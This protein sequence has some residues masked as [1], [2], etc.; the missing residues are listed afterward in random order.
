MRSKV[1][2]L[3]LLLVLSQTGIGQQTV[4][5]DGER[6]MFGDRVEIL[7]DPTSSLT[8]EDVQKS[9][10]F[11]PSNST[12]PNM[13]ITSNAYWVRFNIVNASSSKD[14]SVQISYSLIDSISFYQLDGDRVIQ[15]NH[16][17]GMLPFDSRVIDEHQYYVYPIGTDSYDTVTCY[18]RVKSGTQLML[19]IYVGTRF[20]LLGDLLHKDFLFGIYMGIILVMILYNA[21]I[22]ISLRDK[23]Y[24]FY[25][26]YLLTVVF[27]QASLEGYTFRL[28]LPD[29]PYVATLSIYISS[30]LI[31]IAAIEFAKQFLNSKEMA[32]RLHKISYWFLAV[33]LVTMVL[34][35]FGEYN[36]SY[37][38]ILCSAALSGIYVFIMALKILLKG[39]R[40]ARYFLIAWSAFIISVIVYVLKD[41]GV[42]P[43]N[44]FTASAMQ[45]GSAFE[46]VMLSFALADKINMYREEKDAYQQKA[47]L[48]VKENEKIVRE[49]NIRLEDQVNLR[50]SELQATNE[51]LEQTL[52]DLKEA[53]MQLV[54]SEKMAS[55]GQLTAGI[56]HEINN[57]I[58]FVTS[59]VSPLKRDISILQELLMAVEDIGLRPIS[60][61]EKQKMIEVLKN[62]VDYE[63]LNTEIEHLLKGISEGATRTSDIVKG[64]RLFS[65]LDED[66]VKLANINEGLDSTIAIINHLL[67]G[68]ITVERNYAELPLVECYPGKLNQLFLNM[69]T[70]AIH[71]IEERWGNEDKGKLTI[72]TYRDDANVHIAISDNGTGMT[73]ETKKKL[74]EPFFTTK[75][76]GLGTGLGLSIGWNT[77][78]KHEGVIQVNS[79]IGEG[80]EFIMSIPLKHQTAQN[81]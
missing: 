8:L 19:P 39:S 13:Q 46:A 70:N 67:N 29:Q 37:T 38:I 35:F 32:P 63:Y 17:G 1:F 30:A 21:F 61:E 40:S 36:L 64:L 23:H 66:H 43:Y 47:Y 58:N 45:F 75:D 7:E 3:F 77:I 49:Q 25:I 2:L 31:G 15:E 50:T 14:I 79:K 71:A 26:L 69:M 68:K 6:T 42:L 48:A 24:M 5:F 54:D 59:N 28:L 52:I 73:E 80:T 11:E 22:F 55:L 57:P 76:V 74:F 72:G 44:F 20:Q 53:E 4:S 65:R 56:A 33:Y 78:K 18:I 62:D 16:S 41:F 60:I 10:A 27:T 9:D 34:P 81:D 51:E 12:V